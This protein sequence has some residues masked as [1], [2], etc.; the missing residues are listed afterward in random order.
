MDL[1]D[2]KEKTKEKVHEVKKATEEPIVRSGTE[3]KHPHETTTKTKTTETTPTGQEY[4]KET[5][6]K[7]HHEEY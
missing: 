5:K 7:K 3:E 1:E 2:I 6:T 4:T